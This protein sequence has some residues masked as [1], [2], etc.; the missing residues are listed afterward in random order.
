MNGRRLSSEALVGVSAFPPD[1]TIGPCNGFFGGECVEMLGSMT[2]ATSQEAYHN[3]YC[4]VWS[5]MHYDPQLVNSMIG[6]NGLEAWIMDDDEI[7]SFVC[8]SHIAGIETSGEEK[9]SDSSVG[10]GALVVVGVAGLAGVSF[11]LVYLLIKPRGRN[12]QCLAQELT[13][14]DDDATLKDLATI[15]KTASFL[16]SLDSPSQGGSFPPSPKDLAHFLGARARTPSNWSNNKPSDDSAASDDT[17][18]LIEGAGAVDFT[19]ISMPLGRKKKKTSK[20]KKSFDSYQSCAGSTPSM[21]P[22]NEDETNDSVNDDYD[23]AGLTMSSISQSF[24]DLE[25]GPG[26]F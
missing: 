20:R 13:E 11:M 4:S 16:S 18:V 26:E 14:V 9:E 23:A 2:I 21:A 17:V 15:A 8:H 3:D 10:T 7:G 6:I 1:S 19:G 25:S 12:V 5:S 22:I 24:D